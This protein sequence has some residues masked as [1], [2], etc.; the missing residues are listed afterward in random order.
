[1]AC[2]WEDSELR[3]GLFNLLG[4]VLSGRRVKLGGNNLLDGCR[5][6]GDSLLCD[7]LLGKSF[8]GLSKEECTKFG[9]RS[10]SWLADWGKSLDSGKSYCEEEGSDF[11]HGEHGD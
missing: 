9:V 8:G 4:S 3:V 10:N 5:L 2:S 7:G 11:G 1:M 6:L